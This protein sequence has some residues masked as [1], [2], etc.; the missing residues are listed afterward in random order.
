[1]FEKKATAKELR[2]LKYEVAELTNRLDE[3][4]ERER[5][6]WREKNSLV[7]V[8]IHRPGESTQE[9]LLDDVLN[10][11]LDHLGVSFEP[12]GTQ[13]QPRPRL[14]K[15]GGSEKSG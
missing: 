11:I 14:I 3:V 5:R 9:V 1:M 4:Q 8:F 10:A 2:S 6:Q 13:P 12:A 7:K 15:K